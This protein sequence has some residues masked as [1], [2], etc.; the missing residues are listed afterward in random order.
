M[1]DVVYPEF[2][3]ASVCVHPSASTFLK[4]IYHIAKH[5]I[6]DVRVWPILEIAADN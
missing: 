2:F 5:R 6:I 4:T 1:E 3:I